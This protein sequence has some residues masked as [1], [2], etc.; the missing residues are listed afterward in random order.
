MPPTKQGRPRPERHTLPLQNPAWR[1][2][3]RADRRGRP[4]GRPGGGPPRPHTQGKPPVKIPT[5]LHPNP[6]SR[7]TP[8]PFLSPPISPLCSTDVFKKGNISQGYS[9]LISQNHQSQT[10]IEDAFFSGSG[11]ADKK[12]FTVH[13]EHRFILFILFI[14]FFIFKFQFYFSFS[15]FALRSCV[16]L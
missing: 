15:L 13:V 9:I 8:C 1:S 5:T 12:H 16:S 11:L 2:A 4:E 10:N 6:R 14:C 3:T 7:E